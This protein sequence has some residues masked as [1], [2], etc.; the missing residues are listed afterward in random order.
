MS[1]G[2]ITL[3]CPEP[4]SKIGWDTLPD[5][6]K[7]TLS[8]DFL[9]EAESALRYMSEHPR[10]S[11]MECRGCVEWQLF[12]SVDYLPEEEIVDPVDIEGQPYVAITPEHRLGVGTLV[13]ARYDMLSV[14]IPF[15][16]ADD[17]LEVLIG[18]MKDIRQE[19]E[20]LQEELQ[21]EQDSKPKV[22][23]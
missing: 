4:S 16:D 6:V 13:I 17:H 7:V 14:R 2:K 12:A 21:E 11:L 19:I 1:E 8:E 10:V 22:E 18:S 9:P 15:C 20:E 3:V 23:M 5:L